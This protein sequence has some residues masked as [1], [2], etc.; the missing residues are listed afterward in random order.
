[1]NPIEKLKAVLCGPDGECCIDGSDEDRKIIDEALTQLEAQQAQPQPLSEREAFEAWA[2]G[3]GY[4]VSGR[5]N[6]G[7]YWSNY[8]HGVWKAWQAR[9]AIAKEKTS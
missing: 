9:A 3:Q 6:D 1:M 7:R 2:V 4:K 8:T 5:K